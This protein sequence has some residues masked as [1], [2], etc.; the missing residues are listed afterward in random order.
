M[1]GRRGREEAER[2]GIEEGPGEGR[3]GR[4]DEG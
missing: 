2:E 4:G 1:D 3:E